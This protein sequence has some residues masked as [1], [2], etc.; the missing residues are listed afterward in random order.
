MILR[1]SFSILV[2]AL[3]VSLA[4][5]AGCSSSTEPTPT[6]VLETATMIPT[7]TP[8]VAVEYTATNTP[9]PKHTSTPTNVQMHTPVPTDIPAQVPTA[10]NTPIPTP[11]AVPSNTPTSAPTHTPLPTSTHTPTLVPSATDTPEPTDTPTAI[12]TATNTPL[13]F[14]VLT[15]IPTFNPATLPSIKWQFGDEL[16]QDHK[17]AVIL[18][19]KTMYDYA[20]SLAEP[21][22]EEITVYAYKNLDDLLVAY[23]N[24]WDYEDKEGLIDGYKDEWIGRGGEMVQFDFV[25]LDSGDGQRAKKAAVFLRLDADIN[26]T[27]ENTTHE[28]SHALRSSPG[29][30]RIQWIEEG[31]AKYHS[32]RV[33]AE[34]GFTEYDDFRHAR[35]QDSHSFKELTELW[36][37]MAFQTED[38]VAHYS[39]GFLAAELL[40]SIAGEKALF[41][42]NARVGTG[43]SSTSGTWYTPFKSAFG[44]SPVQFFEMFNAHWTAGF[45]KLEVPDFPVSVQLPLASHSASDSCSNGVAVPN[46]QSDPDL[47]SDCEVLLELRDKLE[48]NGKLNWTTNLSML[49]WDG[50]T[51]SGSPNRVT[52]LQLNVKGLTGQIPSEL[53]KLSGLTNL[54]LGGNELTGEIP[55]ELGKLTNLTRL[56]LGD[57]Q[58]TGEIPAELGRLSNLRWLW[59]GFNSLTGEIPLDLGNLR[60]LEELSIRYNDLSGEMPSELGNLVNVEFLRLEGN[61]FIGCVPDSL[62]IDSDSDHRDS[63]LVPCS[64][65]TSPSDICS[66]GVVVPEPQST[67]GLV[68][69]CELLLSVLDILDPTDKLD[70]WYDR[71]MEDWWGI[72]IDESTNRV[73]GV[74]PEYRD[75]IGKFPIELTTMDNLTHL[76]LEGNQLTG[77]IPPEL[78]NMSNL[79]ELSLGLNLITGE[80]P[81]ELANLTNLTALDLGGNQLTGDIPPELGNISNLKE[82]SLGLNLI[83]GEIPVELANLTNLTALDLGG[84]QL[85]GDIPLELSTLSNLR[86]LVLEHNDLTGDIPVG[87][88]NIPN[89]EWLI[90][91]NNQLTGSI[92]AGIGSIY[93]LTELRLH[94]NRITG[95]IPLE[96]GNLLELEV[97]ILDNNQLIGE[98][99]QELGKLV[100]LVLLDLGGNQFTGCIPESLRGIDQNDFSELKQEFCDDAN[101]QP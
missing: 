26:W 62:L 80:I 60:N 54:S 87:L 94:N 4:I 75:I 79:K 77:E 21:S 15:N 59:L 96:L 76:S 58:F 48:G 65:D 85:T 72:T 68:S 84:N 39:E 44:M 89:L 81:V 82:L 14:H 29:T 2:I 27:I 53:G 28:L 38:A 8:T 69:D 99:P 32:G 78:G 12:P 67:P 37:S 73:T 50:V 33:L 22:V 61:S 16:P 88:G 97:L 56:W 90:L 95:E 93:S 86:E 5:T 10:T 1:V 19:T 100:N 7:S 35:I 13:P 40:A 98:I 66:N 52:E 63:G 9:L 31:V 34:L 64:I 3:I 51:V 30:G 11:T 46:P 20:L 43:S 25:E 101:D 23:A 36:A 55:S 17:N 83:T 57:N 6:P 74:E 49:D 70:W 71:P 45:P 24:F 42:Y 91:S 47:V 18:A 41:D 92:P